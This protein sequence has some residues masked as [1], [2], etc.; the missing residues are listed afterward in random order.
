VS[1]IGIDVKLVSFISAMF[2]FCASLLLSKKIQNDTPE[3]FVGLMHALHP[4]PIDIW[5]NAVLKVGMREQY[6]EWVRR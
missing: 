3:Y 1:I 6:P 4:P 5:G 2:K